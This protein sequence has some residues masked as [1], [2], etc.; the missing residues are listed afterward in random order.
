MNLSVIP[1]TREEA[2]IN[3]KSSRQHLAGNISESLYLNDKGDWFFENILK[4]VCERYIKDS[5]QI[6]TAR[7]GFDQFPI[8]KLRLLN[9]WVNSQRQMEFNPCHNHG[10]VLSFVIWMKIPTN[11]E[12]L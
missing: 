7:N 5:P 4:D 11:W 10:G 8:T 1:G 6:V 12:L 2:T 3:S 9:F